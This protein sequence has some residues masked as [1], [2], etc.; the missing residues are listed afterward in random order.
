LGLVEL[1]QSLFFF[2]P[3]SP[4]DGL[5]LPKGDP[6]MKPGNPSRD[7]PPRKKA[8]PSVKLPCRDKVWVNPKSYVK[9]ICE[10]AWKPAG[11]PSPKF[12][13]MSQIDMRRKKPPESVK[14]KAAAAA[15][16]SDTSDKV[17]RGCCED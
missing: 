14:I 4:G 12:V 1:E 9:N 17:C 6:L 10:Q 11:A 15:G 5:L 8:V 16:N 13:D 7:N 3:R 2:P